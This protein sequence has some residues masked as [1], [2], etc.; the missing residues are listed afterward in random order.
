VHGEATDQELLAWLARI[1]REDAEDAKKK[2][3]AGHA[4]RKLLACVAG[5][6]FCALAAGVSNTGPFSFKLVWS[7]QP[8]P[9]GLTSYV[10][11]S[12]WCHN[13][14]MTTNV[15]TPV[16]SYPLGMVL[17]NWTLGVLFTNATV[18]N[19]VT[20]LVPQQWYTSPVVT[21]PAAQYFMYLTLTNANG[22]A[23]PSNVAL[24]APWPGNSGNTHIVKPN[25]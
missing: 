20:N 14:Y 10:E 16:A 7:A 25:Q 1:G 21:L 23:A 2:A 12:N 11:P 19:G 22:E 6:M 18:V 15:G 24:N 4:S 9:G 3:E 17:T 13:V 8:M 5:I